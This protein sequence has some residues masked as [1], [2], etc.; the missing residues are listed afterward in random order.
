MSHQLN[1]LRL[2]LSH[3]SATCAQGRR[4]QGSVLRAL[5][6][7]L[8]ACALAGL[9][10]VYALA[11]IQGSDYVGST[12]VTDRNLNITEAPA[13]EAKYGILVDSDGN[14]L[15]S[16]GANKKSAMA[17]IT[18]VMTA[19][20]ALE[21]A[22]LDDEYTVSSAAASIGES[23]AGLKA[24]EK[25][26]LESLLELML[27]H[28]SNDAANVIAEG[29]SGSSDAFVE[30]MNE[31]AAD[32]GLKN[33]HYVDPE[34]LDQSGHYTTASDISVLVRY[35]MKNE[36]FRD[37]VKMK[38]TTQTYG[39]S[40]HTFI[41]TNALLAT[42]DSCI[43]VKTGYTDSA[44]ECLASAAEK[45]GVE[46]YAVV[47]GCTDEVQRFTDSY[48]LLDWGFSHY[49]SYTLASADDVL[50]DVPMSGYVNRTVKAGV[51]EDVT[52]CVLDYDGDISVDVKLFDI[53]DGV[54]EGDTV[55]SITWRQGEK[56]VASEPL[57]AKESVGAPMPWTSV[58][59]A[60]V[61]LFGVL[62][63]D[64]AVAQ[65]TLYAQT[66]KVELDTSD[67]GQTVGTK[68]EKQIRAYVTK[69]NNSLY[70]DS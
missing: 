49:R 50:V 26:S 16:R 66:I 31:K 20:V 11:A 5:L 10:P 1:P 13:I 45:D 22:N 41:N 62:T 2:Q 65:S 40:T 51:S 70:S 29:V 42:W 63:G 24:G 58:I 55:G 53:P 17:S 28:S 60:F 15:W 69:Y 56:I 27:V 67:A 37:I 25:L 33:T 64:K 6:C 19:V 43:G 57:V 46:L 48:K 3:G 12:T 18:K 14:V 39:G 61:R 68:L 30:K 44:G 52:S 59:T 47:L 23:S 32:L 9:F 8:L 35:A 7:F 54:S 4:W 38:T 34:G 21:N 36:T